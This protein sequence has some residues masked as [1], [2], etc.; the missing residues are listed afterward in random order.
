MGDIFEDVVRQATPIFNYLID[1]PTVTATVTHR[2]Y[3]GQIFDTTDGADKDQYMESILNGIETFHTKESA[4]VSKRGSGVESAVEV[5]DRVF[6]FF[7]DIE[8]SL[9][10]QI[11]DSNNTVYNVKAITPIRTIATLITVDS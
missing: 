5:G 11:V 6:M 8:C 7:S 4:F 1:C 9:K 10:D 3:T 2:K